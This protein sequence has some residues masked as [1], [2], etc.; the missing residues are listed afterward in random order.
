VPVIANN[1]YFCFV[2]MLFVVAGLQL[3]KRFVAMSQNVNL[4]QTVIDIDFSL[5][6]KCVCGIAYCL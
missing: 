5:A 3:C 6:E 2:F 1:R 4:G